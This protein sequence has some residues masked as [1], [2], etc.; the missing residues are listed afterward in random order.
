M[1]ITVVAAN[2]TGIL[3]R[4]VVALGRADLRT[5]RRRRSELGADRV[6]FVFDVA[7][8]QP[9]TLGDTP[10]RPPHLLEVTIEGGSAA[11]PTITGTKLSITVTPFAQGVSGPGVSCS[12]L[13]GLVSGLLKSAIP[14]A[15]GE[16]C[17]AAGDPACV[18]VATFY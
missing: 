4:L 12:L 5:E 10:K 18:F 2:R 1:T 11:Q 16:G 9:P 3:S 8:S 14:T 15:T 7:G 17:R 6:S 13:A